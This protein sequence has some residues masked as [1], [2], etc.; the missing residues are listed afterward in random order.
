M[1]LI[2]CVI[3]LIVRSSVTFSAAALKQVPSCEFFPIEAVKTN[4]IGTNNILTA[5]DNHKIKKVITLSTDKAA[6]PIN[7]MGMT[8]AL[9]E[10]IMISGNIFNPETRFM[11][12]RY[13]NVIASR[14]S[15]I[16]LFVSK[17]KNKQ[18]LTITDPMM[19]RFLMSFW[20]SMSSSRLILHTCD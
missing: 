1:A 20:H 8:K 12:V 10:R 5:A 19:T 2:L 15:V 3:W 11:C 17:I 18:P 7:A 6:Y 4:V 14:G 13:G 16:P 9:Q